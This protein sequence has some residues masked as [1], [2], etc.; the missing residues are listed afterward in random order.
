ME[1]RSL[2]SSYFSRFQVKFRRR[3]EGK[4]DYKARLNMLSQAKNKFNAH[5]YLLVVRLSNRD[6]CSQITIA[7]ISGDKVICS[8]YAHELS[9]YGLGVG[10]TN[11]SAAYCVGL[12]CAARCK[13]KFALS[14]VC[15]GTKYDIRDSSKTNTICKSP[16]P[17]NLTL[18]TGLK[19][20]STGSK[21][22]AVLKGAVDGGITVPHNE[23]RFVGFDHITKTN[24]TSIMKKYLSGT[25]V[26]DFMIDLKDEEPTKF[27][28][29]FSAYICAQIK[30]EELSRLYEKVH[31]SLLSYTQNTEN[32]RTRTAN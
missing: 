8:C 22:F 24:D 19:R 13:S 31:R 4:T 29:H 28:S 9:S 21:I 12:L 17:F 32:S 26:R 5:K 3:R 14:S 11:Y 16:R 15:S 7:T 30:P 1:V 27:R 2:K 20:T 18:D 6:I 10:L 25:H 23:K